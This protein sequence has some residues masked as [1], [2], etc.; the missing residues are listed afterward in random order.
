MVGTR[1]PSTAGRLGPPRLTESINEHTPAGGRG[2]RG[3]PQLLDPVLSGG[4][5]VKDDRRFRQGCSCRGCRTT[6]RSM[7]TAVLQPDLNPRQ[8]VD[9]AT[10]SFVEAEAN[11][12]PL[13]PPGV[14]KTHIAVVLA[15]CRAGYR[16]TSPVST[17]W[18]ATSRPP[19]PPGG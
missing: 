1:I 9:P 12:A 8:A 5:A 16:A 19:R 3:L 11:A 13:G 6:R 15:A 10:L 2:E 17:T 14:D 4:L 18:C 7:S